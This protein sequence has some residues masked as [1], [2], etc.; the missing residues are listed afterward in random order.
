VRRA[1]DL[2]LRY[3]LTVRQSDCITMAA[4]KGH[5]YMTHYSDGPDGYETFLNGIGPNAKKLYP[6]EFSCTKYLCA[7]PAAV[8]VSGVVV[9]DLYLS[10][11]LAQHVITANAV[12]NIR[13]LF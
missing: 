9:H 2:S 4:D 3:N 12:T 5:I 6:G 7:V 8:A 11:W 1:D 13:H 10:V